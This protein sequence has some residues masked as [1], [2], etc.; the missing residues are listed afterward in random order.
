MMLKNVIKQTDFFCLPQQFHGKVPV[1]ISDDRTWINV[2]QTP[3]S[4]LA[5]QNNTNLQQFTAT[6]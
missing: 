3:M 1:E 2:E 6:F 4:T 5:I